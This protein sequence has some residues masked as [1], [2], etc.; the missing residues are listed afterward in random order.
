MTIR[1]FVYALITAV[2]AVFA[3]ANWSVITQPTTLNLLVARI[4][5]PLG[6]V[7]L[8]VVLVV[9]AIDVIMLQA[10]RM[11]W[12]RQQRSTQRELERQRTLAESA[13]A[14]RLDALHAFVESETAAIRAQLDHITRLI[15]PPNAD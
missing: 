3:L 7:M 14:S 10:Q 6:A 11:S 9:I 8:L 4:E 2:I 15:T 13:E 1:G 5:A 12:R